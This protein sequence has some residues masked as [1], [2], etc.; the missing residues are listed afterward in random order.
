MQI[1]RVLKVL[2]PNIIY[3]LFTD[4][5]LLKVRERGLG[6]PLAAPLGDHRDKMVMGPYWDYHR[7]Q[8]ELCE[9]ILTRI[10]VTNTNE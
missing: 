7:H 5:G 9:E 4:E 3:Y 1:T 2:T 10:S 8:A 6:P